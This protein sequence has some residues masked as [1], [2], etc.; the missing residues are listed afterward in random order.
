VTHAPDIKRKN[1]SLVSCRCIGSGEQD[2]G[3]AMRV[4]K[5]KVF[6]MCGTKVLLCD[7]GHAAS[8]ASRVANACR[9]ALNQRLMTND[10]VM[11]T[12]IKIKP[13]AMFCPKENVAPN[14][15]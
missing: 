7:R 6:G 15:G 12:T 14:H 9:R 10:L 2:V 4:R 1:F 13:I 5:S 3:I 8:P 11:L